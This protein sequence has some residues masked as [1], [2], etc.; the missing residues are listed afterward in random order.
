MSLINGKLICD[1]HY[2]RPLTQEIV[3]ITKGLAH[4]GVATIPSTIGQ[5]QR[6]G[7][8]RGR[9]GGQMNDATWFEMMYVKLWVFI[10][11]S[12]NLSVCLY[13]CL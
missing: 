7:Q 3:P 8:S 13:P 1:K 9:G 6:Q 4:Y 12:V 2:S 5:E 11:L 10:S